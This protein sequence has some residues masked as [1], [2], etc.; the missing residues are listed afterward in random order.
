[1][2]VVVD[3]GRSKTKTVPRSGDTG[4][5]DIALIMRSMKVSA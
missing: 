1:M 4:P 5:A 3:K 2:V